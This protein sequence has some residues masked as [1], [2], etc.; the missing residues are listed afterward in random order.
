M[1]FFN[2]DIVKK[3]LED[4]FGKID[5]TLLVY[6]YEEWFEKLAKK[7]ELRKI[8]QNNLYIELEFSKEK[9][10]EIKGEKLMLIANNLTNNFK[11]SYRHERIKITLYFSKLERHF[12]FYLVE[13]LSK[14]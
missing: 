9:S 6:M 13:L 5:E 1:T 10:G 14:L 3:E 4:R 7:F 12:I 2:S 11:F 8:S